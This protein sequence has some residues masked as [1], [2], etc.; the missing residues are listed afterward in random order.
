MKIFLK[1]L[2]RKLEGVVID[3]S[4]DEIYTKFLSAELYSSSSSSS[5]QQKG[6]IRLF[7]Y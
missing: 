2:K 5:I 1:Q 7:R 4:I 6:T 3:Y